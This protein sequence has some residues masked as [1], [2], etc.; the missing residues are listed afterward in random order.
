MVRWSATL[1]SANLWSHYFDLS[2]VW[3]AKEL[4]STWQANV[5]HNK[6]APNQF[7][8][9]L[10]RLKLIRMGLSSSLIIIE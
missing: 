4:D 9:L 2:E 1:Q 6:I 5:K 7:A 10:D 3:Q 8:D